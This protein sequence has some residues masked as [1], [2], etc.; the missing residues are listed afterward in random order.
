[1][2]VPLQNKPLKAYL[3]ADPGTNLEVTKKDGHIT[4]NVPGQAPDGILSIVALE[5]EGDPQVLPIPT[6]GKTGTASSVDATASVASLFDGDPK[7]AWKTAEGETTGWVEVDLGEDMK[8][9]NFSVSEPWHPWDHHGQ[10][11]TLQYKKDGQWM[12]VIS[13][14]TNGCG[15]SQSFEPV[16]GRYFRLNITGAQ[17]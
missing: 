5:F 11:F 16:T 8:I 14:K 2:K 3:L 15:H 10:V 17:R 12:D 6:A 9:G 7:N 13:G 4:I 1:M